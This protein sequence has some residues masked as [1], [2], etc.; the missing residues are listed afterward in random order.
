[1]SKLNYRN[2][3]KWSPVDRNSMSPID[4]WK[5]NSRR[6]IRVM[7][8]MATDFCHHINSRHIDV[9]DYSTA[10]AIQVLTSIANGTGARL[11]KIGASVRTSEGIK[12]S[13]EIT[14]KKKRWALFIASSKNQS[15]LYQLESV[16]DSNKMYIGFNKFSLVAGRV[17]VRTIAAHYAQVA[18]EYFKVTTD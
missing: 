13:A 11:V 8:A 5:R 15:T 14:Y 17:L 18:Q 2:G 16:N 7:K 1:M 10:D 9:G 6:E 12:F 3:E 4:Y